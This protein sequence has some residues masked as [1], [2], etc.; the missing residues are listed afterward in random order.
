MSHRSRLYRTE[1]IVLRRHDLGET[2]RIVTFFTPAYGKLRAV[3]KGVRRPASRK[4]GHLEPFTRSN[5]LVA[6]G[7]DLDIVTQAETIDSYPKLRQDLDRLGQA[8]YVVELVDR[9]GVQEAESQ[10]L[11]HLTTNT[12]ERLDREKEMAAPL[13]YF[14]VRLLDLS[15]YRPELQRCVNCLEE[16]QP[17]DQFFS[18]NEGGLLCPNCGPNNPYARPLSLGALKVLRHYQRNGYEEAARPQ[19]GGSVALELEG[20]MESYLNHLVERDLHVPAFVRQVR[21]VREVGYGSPPGTK[22]A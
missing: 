21:E 18:D 13:R 4:A 2:D 17:Q 20:L 9:F 16:A 11:F 19:I 8:A 5:L 12:L 22:P 15:G 7:R 10:A 3:A 6:K 1:S 14:Q